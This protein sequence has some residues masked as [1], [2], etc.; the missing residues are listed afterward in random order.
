MAIRIL[1]T[2]AKELHKVDPLSMCF[3]AVALMPLIEKL[4]SSQWTQTW[5]ADDSSCVGKLS[6]VKC[7]FEMLMKEGPK[8][9]YFPESSKIC[10][11]CG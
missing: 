3:Y 5:Y 11:S 2:V 6:N 9:G 7:W 10:F 1:C 8:F 4:K